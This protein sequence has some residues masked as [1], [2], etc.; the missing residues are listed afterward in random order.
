VA[1]TMRCIINID[2]L[3]FI[4]INIGTCQC[5]S[6]LPTQAGWVGGGGRCPGSAA[7][8]RDSCLLAQERPR[9]FWGTTVG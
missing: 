6:R 5:H 2:E 4:F 1:Q 7:A 3:W 8:E 9:A